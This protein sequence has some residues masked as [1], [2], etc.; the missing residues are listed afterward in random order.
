MTEKACKDIEYANT[1][2]EN[3]EKNSPLLN[4]HNTLQPRNQHRKIEN[5]HLNKSTYCLYKFL[6]EKN[7][8]L[9]KGLDRKQ[10][11]IDNLINLLNGVTTKSVTR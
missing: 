1:E 10:K 2:L 5:A 3:I 4:H 8:F 6:Q 7:G 9:R 11:I